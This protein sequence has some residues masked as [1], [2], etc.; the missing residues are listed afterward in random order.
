M[1]R[2]DVLF[3]VQH[4]LGIGHLRRAAIIARHL[5]RAGLDVV[6]VSGG[7]PIPGLDVGVARFVQLPPT[8]AQDVSFRVLLDGDDRPVTERWKQKRA[9]RL[10]SLFRAVRPRVLLIETYPFGRRQ[11]RF[12][13]LPLL[14]EASQGIGPVWI[15][16][17]VRDLLSVQ[18][19]SDRVAWILDQIKRY[20]DLV[21]VHG[22]SGF[23]AFDQTFP[24]AGSIGHKLRYTGY[25]VDETSATKTSSPVGGGEVIVSAGGGAVSE[26]LL[27][28][29]VSA[30]A[31][32]PLAH[33]T[34]RVLTGPNLSEG[35]FRYLC[36]K[37]PAGVIVER[38]RPDFP[39]LL[40]R[41]AL[42][43]SQAGYNTVMEVLRARRPAVVVPFAARAEAEQSLRARLLGERSRLIVVEEA[44]LTGETLAEGVRQ[45]MDRSRISPG[46]S[47]PLATNG[48]ETTTEIIAN[49][50]GGPAVSERDTRST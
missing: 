41:C 20:F 13:L 22:D 38:W 25:V 24:M 10:L 47:P 3:Y 1:E 5:S 44:R 15:V 19:T 39:S 14:D 37:A 29:A 16:C 21:L 4:L 50:I 26:P 9:R 23:V 17:S 7:I 12:E 35:R 36:D 40:S 48:A 49:L 18:P 11:L 27:E 30:R 45:A 6:F 32:T 34:W 2:A 42:S 46:P 33:A 31:L 8:R 43:I 28:A